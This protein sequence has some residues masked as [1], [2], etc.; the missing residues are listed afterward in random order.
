MASHQLLL[1][2][3]RQ[4][5]L[6][7]FQSLLTV[8]LLLTCTCA[9]VHH[10]RPQLL[11]SHKTGYRGLFWKLA[12]IGEFRSCL[13]YRG[14]L[15]SLIAPISDDSGERLSPVISLGCIMMGIQVLFL[16]DRQ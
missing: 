6:F 12:R 8:L 3:V 4:A 16:N 5:A 9:Y 14:D 15:C 11:D 2:L 1:L 13:G 10:V 7:N